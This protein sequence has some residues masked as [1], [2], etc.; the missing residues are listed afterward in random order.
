MP[1]GC[2]SMKNFTPTVKAIA[3]ASTV[4][5]LMWFISVSTFSAKEFVDL[6]DFNSETKQYVQIVEV[7]THSWFT[8]LLSTVSLISMGAI[9]YREWMKDLA[10][11]K[12]DSTPSVKPPV[13]AF[14]K[15]PLPAPSLLVEDDYEPSIPVTEIQVPRFDAP[16]MVQS[17]VVEEDLTENILSALY[18]SPQRHLLCVAETRAGKTSLLLGLMKTA[19][20]RSGGQ[21]DIYIGTVKK[22]AFLGLESQVDDRQY[23]RRIFV[24]QISGD[25][26]TLLMKTLRHCINKMT[27]RGEER[28]KAEFN[29]NPAPTYPPIILILDE[30]NTL[31]SVADKNGRKS[32]FLSL[33]DAIANT[34][35]EDNVRIWIF[36]QD[37]QVQNLGINSGYRDNFGI[38]IL[39]RIYHDEESNQE[40]FA[41]KKMES[42]FI[43]RSSLVDNG[44]DYWDNFLVIAKENRG[45]PVIWT[46]LNRKCCL[47]PY[48]PD[49]K[50]TKL[51]RSEDLSEQRFEKPVME[52]PL[53]E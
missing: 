39:G 26:L 21:A 8:K 41:C 46:T 37:Y 52:E 38:A 13:N 53:D 28:E 22:G 12:P 19:H 51:W 7:K 23:P 9:A 6:G 47:M 40:M 29:G 15:A 48:M 1:R 20:E 18:F 4:G 44:R 16:P 34:G 42:A 10:K 49:I 2:S 17:A 50:R 3:T 24:D 31:V 45:R 25:G 11:A 35:A 33:V 30:M 32:E 27:A 36:G 5:S 14:I 43:G